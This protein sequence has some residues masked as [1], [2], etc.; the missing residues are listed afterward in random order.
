[1][2]PLI[3]WLRVA[4]AAQ[5]GMILANFVLPHKLAIRE[6]PLQPFVN[7][8]DMAEFHGVANALSF[9]VCG[10]LGWTLSTRRAAGK[11]GAQ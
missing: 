1:M 3:W 7:L 11:E 9:S 6:F 2:Q 4:G 10:L 5:V 8:A